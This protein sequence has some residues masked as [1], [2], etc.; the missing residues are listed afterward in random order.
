MYS[1]L[2]KVFNF[3]INFFYLILENLVVDLK[4]SS[5]II[6]NI[7]DK[8]ESITWGIFTQNYN[9]NFI[10]KNLYKIDV[11]NKNNVKTNT[12]WMCREFTEV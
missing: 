6:N 4:I 11:K 10:L 9:S 7:N 12:T 8:G 2:L 3:I 1:Q 5:R